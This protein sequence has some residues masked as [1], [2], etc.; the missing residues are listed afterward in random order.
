MRGNQCLTELRW[1]GTKA[2]IAQRSKIGTLSNHDQRGFFQK[3]VG[4]E[5]DTQPASMWRVLIRG[6]QWVSLL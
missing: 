2:Y 5:A 6:L 3:Q 1:P 4:A